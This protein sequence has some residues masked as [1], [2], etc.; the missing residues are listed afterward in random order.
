MGICFSRLR[1]LAG[2]MSEG[3]SSENFPV[4]QA[5]AKRCRPKRFLAGQHRRETKTGVPF[6]HGTP[7]LCLGGCNVITGRD[8][9]P[10]N[11]ELKVATFGL[12]CQS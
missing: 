9:V 8:A 12:L 4:L 7:G 1:K 3:G 6:S 11:K 5:S 2:R 10:A